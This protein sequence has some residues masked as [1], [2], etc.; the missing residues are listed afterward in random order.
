VATAAPL[1]LLLLLEELLLP[2]ELLLLELL[3]LIDVLLLP[4]VERLVLKD[5]L[6]DILELINEVDML[7]ESD[8]ELLLVPTGMT[9][10]ITFVDLVQG[11][12]DAPITSISYVPEGSQGS[13]LE[14]VPA[15]I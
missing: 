14:V 13:V 2:L 3:K 15:L 12:H 8:D 11:P 7:L 10:V 9:V 6:V 1:E 5:S 4:L